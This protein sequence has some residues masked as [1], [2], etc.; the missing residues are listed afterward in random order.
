MVFDLFVLRIPVEMGISYHQ[1]PTAFCLELHNLVEYLEHQQPMA[2][3]VLPLID[4][5]VDEH[6]I[7]DDAAIHQPQYRGLVSDKDAL[8]ALCSI[9]VVVTES[10]QKLE[11]A[12]AAVDF[13]E[14]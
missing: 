8:Q 1:P 3:A 9:S 13:L 5:S 7:V 11:E 14:A 4:I 12:I 10:D 2:F 6:V